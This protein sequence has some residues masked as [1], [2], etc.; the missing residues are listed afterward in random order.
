MGLETAKKSIL[1]VDDYPALCRVAALFLGHCGYDV[2]TACGAA[3][4]KRMARELGRVD[5][6]L[7]D[8]NMPGISG[9]ELAEWFQAASPDTAIVLMSGNA[10]RLDSRRWRYFVE[11]PFVHLDVLANAIRQALEDKTLNTHTP[12]AA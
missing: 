5:L 1:V 8:V 12:F 11:K 10:R 3:E 6:L 9:I 4:A 7:T 2:H